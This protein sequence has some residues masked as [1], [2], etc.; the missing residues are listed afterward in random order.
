MTPVLIKNTA[1]M[2][3]AAA[4]YPPKKLALLY[5]GITLGGGFLT[6]LL[7][8]GVGLMMENT[9]G[10]S[11][12]GTR[13]WLET[14]ATVVRLLVQ[15][16]APLLSMGFLHGTLLLAR[17]KPIGPRTLLAGPRRW[18]LLLRHTLFQSLIFL[19]LGY[20]A[21]QVATVIFTFLPGA[22][23]AMS[24]MMDMMENP[25]VLEG[26]ITDAQLLQMLKAMAP[27]Y[28]IAMV[29]FVAAFVPLSYRLRLSGYRVME[30]AP[31]GAIQATL[32][33][34]RLMK[35]NCVPLFKLDLSF[36]WYYLLQGALTAVVA[37]LGLLPQVSNLLY[38]IGYGVYCLAMLLLEYK[39]L[40]Y[41]Q[42]AYAVF[43]QN[44]L[45]QANAPTLPQSE[46]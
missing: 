6:L 18:A 44:T 35:G 30:E 39:Y 16:A 24:L 17:E 28:M 45:E 11:G 22:E 23:S 13:A 21:L 42:I 1:R 38:V 36:W 43:Y 40:A 4:A 14:L 2:R 19:C 15:I 25:A 9:G 34:I 27:A 41:V 32:Q 8:L 31:V 37:V 5:A 29:L 10:L 3:L 12:L 33:S 26:N 7:S 20:L 46:K